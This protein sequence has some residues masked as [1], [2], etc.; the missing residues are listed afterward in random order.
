MVQVL[1]SFG[2]KPA[3]AV[4]SQMA[5]PYAGW[6]GKHIV[7]HGWAE[8]IGAFARNPGEGREAPSTPME[9]QA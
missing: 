8:R 3:L 1:A 2:R 9:E 6:I 4:V 5:S 7:A